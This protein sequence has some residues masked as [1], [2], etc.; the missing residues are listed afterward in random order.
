MRR[1]HRNALIALGLTG[2]VAGAGALAIA[3]FV[4]FDGLGGF[5]E[6]ELEKVIGRNVSIAGGIDISP[7]LNAKFTANDLSIANPDWAPDTAMIEGAD[8]TFELAALPLLLDEEAEIRK[9]TVRNAN[10]SIRI[11]Q[12]G[13]LNWDLWPDKPESA[14]PETPTQLLDGLDIRSVRII[15]SRLS[16]YDARNG[17]SGEGTIEEFVLSSSSASRPISIEFDGAY[18]G[19]ALTL[20]GEGGSLNTLLDTTSTYPIEIGLGSPGVSGYV[21]GELGQPMFSGN[22]V[23]DADLQ[24]RD[25]SIVRRF[26]SQTIPD[27]AEASL[28]FHAE[29]NPSGWAFSDIDMT[30]RVGEDIE[31]A[32]RG[33]TGRIAEE[34]FEFALPAHGNGGEFA[35]LGA[36]VGAELPALGEWEVSAVMNYSAEG[37]L[38]SN[39]RGRSVRADG[40]VANAARGWID[41]TGEGFEIEADISASGPGSDVLSDLFGAE[42]PTF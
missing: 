20:D 10:L 25:P 17:N 13:Q 16:W 1:R 15:D 18:E 23:L 8:V 12:N 42:L 39:F 2:T 6:K 27:E 22:T 32:G 4:D 36:V 40:M 5:A 34:R 9:L 33:G 29:T 35:Q 38:F 28:R 30:F 26:T 3:H 31:I 21:E 37:F 24:V 41:L 19:I 11:S 14:P 7:S